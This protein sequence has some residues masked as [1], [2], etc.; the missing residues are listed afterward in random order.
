MRAMVKLIIMGF[1]KEQRE[2]IGEFI[3]VIEALASDAYRSL[4]KIEKGMDRPLNRTEIAY[5]LDESIRS[6]VEILQ[7][8]K[9]TTTI[10]ETLID[11]YYS[12]RKEPYTV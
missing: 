11:Y 7:N 8:P 10:R 3:S 1:S 5:S 9:T 2:E 6:T 12:E 4:L